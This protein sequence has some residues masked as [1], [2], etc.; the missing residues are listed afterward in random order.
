MASPPLQLQEHPAVDTEKG[1]TFGKNR[2]PPGRPE[3]TK[4]QSSI[5]KLEER[6]RNTRS[7]APQQKRSRKNKREPRHREVGRSPKRQAAPPVASSRL[8]AEN[9]PT[10]FGTSDTPSSGASSRDPAFFYWNARHFGGDLLRPRTCAV[11][12]TIRLRT[13]PGSVGYRVVDDRVLG[14][15]G[16]PRPKKKER[17]SQ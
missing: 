9:V 7:C 16:A 17:F 10:R 12:S 13:V 4:L 5:A 1:M 6:N 14:V 2:K 15:V 11:E 8:V 3:G